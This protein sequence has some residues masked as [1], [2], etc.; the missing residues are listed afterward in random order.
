MKRAVRLSA[1]VTLVVTVCIAAGGTAVAS[2]R[3]GTTSRA[4]A[5]PWSHVPVGGPSTAPLVSGLRRLSHP[6]ARDHLP[7]PLGPA[8]A[9]VTVGANPVGVVVNPKTHT[10]YVGNGNDSTISVF[11][12]ATCNDVRTTGCSQPP[13][14]IKTGSGPGLFAVNTATD[15]IYV[16]NLNDN[17]VS[18]IDGSTCNASNTSGCGQTAALVQVGSGPGVPG[19]DTATNTIYVPNGND[20]TVSVINGATCDAQNTSGCNQ[21]PPTVAAG[22]GADQVAVDPSTH[23]V[24]VANF[25]DNTVSVID[26]ASCNATNSSGCGQT[27]T[28]VDADFQPVGILFDRASH[29]VYVPA[30]GSS[31]LGAL[32]MIDASACNATHT[33]G[34]SQ[35]PRSTPIG[36]APIWI[37][38]D[39]TTHTVYV[40]NQEDSSVS[41]IDASTCNGATSAGCRQV[42]P[43][44]A[45]GFDMGGVGVDPTTHTV[46]GSSQNNNTVSV[47]NGARCNASNTSGCTAYAATT[48][49]RR[50]PQ[51]VGVDTSTGTLYVGNNEENTVSVIDAGACNATHRNGCGR[52]W[53]T[54]TLDG[55]AFFGVAVDGR[56]H[57]IYVS[58]LFTNSGPGDVAM[59]DGA[60]CNAHDSSGCGNTPTTMAV[61]NC[62]A[63]IAINNLTRTV[64]VANACDGT[65]SVFS[66]A[67]CNAHVTSGCSDVATVAV[68]NGP[69]PIA[70]NEKTDTVYVGNNGDS[71]VSV[72]NGAT[73]NA[74]DPSGCGQKPATVQ[75]QDSPYS[76]A[77]DAR[78]NTVYAANAGN[79]IFFTGYANQTSSISV[80]DGRTCNGS[81][82]S[83]CSQAPRELPVG[84]FPWGVA[85]DP[86]T[87]LVYVTSIVDSSLAVFNGTTCNGHNTSQCQPTLYRQLTGGWPNYIGLDPGANTVYI[88]NNVDGTVSLYSIGS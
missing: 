17:T 87:D 44:L 45:S 48:T 1:A 80:I 28:T 76:L 35:A 69:N 12:A 15:T 63:G 53:P 84:G 55:P 74:A 70:I 66:E 36:S 11:N 30:F 88:P 77:V 37:D 86:V 24:Y 46:Y 50:G 8:A 2:S 60:T 29:T 39:A 19:I 20:G 59:I 67:T 40:A 6:D 5:N 10:V 82:T 83:G 56:T 51:P 7:A 26:G 32:D 85:V 57:T 31:S 33:S 58:T 21:A 13:A 4:P 18:V 49:I 61:G 68:G 54:V 65:V 62:P 22:S 16:G 79:E 38:E 81:D 3:Q 34:C 23:T 42:A 14:T 9:T 64:Y 43:A 73:C 25:N 52:S 78:T 47:L 27:P 71:T 41:A 75:I 72:I